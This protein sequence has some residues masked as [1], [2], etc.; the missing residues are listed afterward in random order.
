MIDDKLKKE[1]GI[2]LGKESGKRFVY[3]LCPETEDPLIIGEKA[4]KA[5]GPK[6]VLS[7]GNHIFSRMSIKKGL[8]ILAQVNQKEGF[9]CSGC[10]W[11]DPEKRSFAEFCENGAK[12]ISLEGTDKKIKPSFFK[13]WSVEE[14]S[15][16][17][18][19]WLTELGRLTRPMYLP[20]GSSHYEEVSWAKA[21]ELISKKITSLESQERASF[22]T[23]GRTSNEAAFLYQLFVRLLGTNNLPDC[24]NMCH[25]SSGVALGESIGIGKGTVTLDDFNK[26][27]LILVVG[28]NPGTNHPRMLSAL[29]K[30]VTEKGA[31]VISIN[32]L[33]ESGTASFANPQ[34]LEGLLGLGLPLASHHI[35]IKINGD[36]PFFQGVMKS[37]F[38]KI[39][40]PNNN[41]SLDLDFIKGKT[42]GF[43]D[44]RKNISKTSWDD[45]IR[46]SGVFK[47]EMESLAE[48]Y[49]KSNKTIIC[50]AMGLTQHE[51]AV[52]NIQEIVN[53]LLLK[54]NFGKP[55]AGA[56]PVR[57]HSNVQG[58]RTM[59]IHEKPSS[60]FIDN[61]DKA[62]DYS[63]PRKAGFNTVEVIKA[64]EDGKVDLFFALGGNFLSATPDTHR[65]AKALQNC[66]M[67]VQVSINLNRSHLVTG[68][69]ALI[70]PCLARSEKDVTNK[71]LQ[72]VTVENS[73]SFV[74]SSKGA[75]EPI[76]TELKSEVSIISE[77]AE[78]TLKK[79]EEQGVP[80]LNWKGF[81]EN[82]DLIRSLIEKSIPGFVDYNKRIKENAGFYL[83]HP[84]R[85]ERRFPTKEG[86]ALFTLHA[87]PFWKLKKG[88]YHMM[89]IRTHDQF[90]TT[91]YGKDDRYRGIYGQRRVLFMNSEDMANEGFLEKDRINIRSYFGEGQRVVKNF[92]VVPFD[93]PKGCTATY[94]PESNELVHLENHAHKS[95]TPVSKSLVVSFEK[96]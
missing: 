83:P 44:F 5:A 34:K 47:K 77:I 9:D 50:W 55:G 10:A 86:K 2:K 94:F 95:Y 78:R 76:D 70:L 42:I 60:S 27:E 85:D 72:F 90:N 6:A 24:S 84:V 20:K 88:Q 93:I 29:Q 4:T 80:S 22:Y 54:G 3:P 32:P 69:E 52:S 11:P 33:F 91:I 96:V 66:S 38:E 71:G 1:E 19:L 39:G 43:E 75:L 41:Y 16:K 65:T 14:L 18:D 67:T 89:T 35:P 63:F 56:C 53:L 15:L 46:G 58:D 59:G 87:I 49:L 40:E 26:A 73:M 36:V 45:L 92:F 37:I 21:F 79:R 68:D 61:L 23:S 31:R 74:H 57:G 8:K 30:A 51:N 82:Y 13:K 62:F 7:T 17:S 28:Q 25:E 12:A 48:A 81:R 64:M